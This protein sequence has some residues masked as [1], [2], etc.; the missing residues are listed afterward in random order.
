[1]NIQQLN[2]SEL[3]E[4]II[5]NSN[6]LSKDISDIALKTKQKY[7]SNKIFARGLIEFT[8][9]CKNNCYYCGIRADNKNAARYRL[10]KDE[11][12]S[13]CNIGHELGFST[14]VLQGGED[15]NYSDKEICDII[16]SIKSRYPDC[17]VTLS[18]GEKTKESYKAYRSSGA[19][20]YLLR[21][22]TANNEHYKK[23]HP[24]C[25]SLDSRKQCLYN[26]KE[27]GFQ[28]GAG[29]MVGSPYQT[30]E[31]LSEDLIFLKELQPEM[32]GIGPFIPHKDTQFKDFQ[33]GSIN[34][35]LTMIA[36]TRLMLP[37]ALIPSTTALASL[38]P[39]NGRIRG[40]MA[41]ANVVMPNL[42]P[43]EHKGKYSLYDNKLS[44]GNEAAQ[45]IEI[46]KR[47]IESSGNILDMSRG[48]HIK[49]NNIERNVFHK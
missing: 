31:N 6:N 3:T 22:E 7:Y 33:P 46:L 15:S 12:L 2:K 39:K 43:D 30:Y 28:T 10:S 29:F 20:R 9:I 40:F 13:C 49:T 27:L 26:L 1:M 36:M 34:L 18:I 23:L 44:T 24:K 17:A 19:D 41:G 21:H 35:T 16:Y 5:K 42:S 8:S 45:S 48:D 32:I 4:L 14:F 37:E 47:E 11:I 25:M 38:D